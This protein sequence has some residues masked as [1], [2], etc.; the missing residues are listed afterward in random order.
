[1]GTKA[2]PIKVGPFL[3]GLNTFSDPTMVSDD[4]AVELLNFDVDL[5]GG[6]VS[7]PPMQRMPTNAGGRYSNRILGIYTNITTG[8]SYIVFSGKDNADAPA[9]YFYN[10]T[11]SVYGTVTATMG[12]AAMTQWQNKCWL[13]A[14]PGSAN[15]GGSW[16]GTTFTAISTMPKG[17]TAIVHKNYLFVG[18]GV[19][20]TTNPSRVYWSKV[21]DGTDWTDATA[22]NG[23]GDGDGQPLI[24]LYSWNGTIVAWKSRSTYAYGFESQPAKGQIQIVSSTIGLE[25]NDAFTEIENVIYVLYEGDIYSIS[26]WVWEQVNQ[27]VPFAY[28]NNNTGVTWSNAS[29]SM[30]NG[31]VMARF[32][33]NIYVYNTK[34]RT[35]A[36]WQTTWTPH[37][38]VRSPIADPVTGVTTFYC[39]NYLTR[40]AASGVPG[41]YL[42]F[43]KDT[44][45]ALDTETFTCRL[46]SKVYSFNVPY[47]YKRL[48][49]WGVDMLSRSKIDVIVTP[50]VYGRPIRIMDVDDR[51]IASLSTR[52]INS[53]L[54]IDISVADSANITNPN[55]V[56]MFV[57]YLKSLRFRQIQFQLSSTIDGTTN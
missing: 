22:F 2:E 16:D 38:F 8:K 28:R 33:D 50:V 32:Y 40:A 11:D 31:R 15:P 23:I 56:R 7:R 45:T 20:N 29:L 27:K 17:C 26:N 4:D 3:G 14:P 53:L 12:A 39:G 52:P 51:T 10:I 49:W 5:D 36:L 18:T 55:G 54:D 9:T 42:F 46:K 37:K 6:L 1:M 44:Y 30:A 41:N 13:I 35:W 57:K 43:W 19:L 48:M 25:N 24:A 47:T 21:N 34:T